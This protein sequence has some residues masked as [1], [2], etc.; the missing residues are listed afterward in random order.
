MRDR[1]VTISSRRCP[2]VRLTRLLNRLLISNSAAKP[3]A[4][5]FGRVRA[6]YPKR[7][8]LD[9]DQILA[10]PDETFRAAG[11]SRAKDRSIEGSRSENNR[12]DRAVGRALIQMSDD[13]VIARLT[14]VRGIGRWTVEMLLLFDLGRPDAG[15]WTI[16]EFAKVSPRL[17]ANETFPRRNSS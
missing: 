4:T 12:W 3:H 1:S 15:Q 14:A 9:P 2:S 5:I 16:T 8:W 13:E 6:L 11:L 7:K 10:T 17:L